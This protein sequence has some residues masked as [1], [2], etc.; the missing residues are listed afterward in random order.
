MKVVVAIDSFKGSLSSME[1]GQAI[2]EGVKRVYQNAEVVV[3]PLADGGEGTVEALVEGMGGIF[4]TKEVTGPLGE[5]V[6]AVYGVIE[7]EEDS[8]KTAIIEMSAAAGITLVPEKSRNP[9][10][11]TTYG[12]GELILDAIERGC[13]HFIVGIGGSATN[14]GGVGMLQ[15]LGYDFLTR[16][17]KAISYG[18]DGL[19]ELA[20]I[21]DV[22]VHPKL[23]ECTFKV[24]CDV[25]NPL[26]GEN[27]SSAIFGPQKGAT[28]EMVQEL[29]QLLLHYA[30]LSKEMNANA[31][32]FY[33]GTG[34]A[35]GMGFAFL[36]YTNA[37][38]ESGIQI[39]LTETKLEELI[40]TAD[41]VVTGE[42]RLDGQT[43]LGKAPIGVASLAKKHQKKVLAFAGA[44]T[45][46]AKECNQ[47]GIDA[48]FP[49]LRGIV[50]LK[51]AMDKENAHRN[52]V[53]TVEQVFRVVEMMKE[54][55]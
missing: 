21:E 34:A 25:T 4:V 38:L 28:P 27:G 22:N 2:A 10:N 42:G 46:D 13:R 52:M 11:T 50:T 5:K 23:K 45:P 54:G 7:S 24:A 26:C 39:V 29:D 51:E 12:V 8:S 17:G 40:K 43:A 36:T 9:M 47:H 20:S 37:A 1:A 32:R 14:D 48:F 41:F 31:D 49:I 16:E 44:V 35:G 19:R 18:G 3:R 30:E 55:K 33:P 6:D 53:D 15:A